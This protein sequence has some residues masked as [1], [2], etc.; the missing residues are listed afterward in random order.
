LAL[1]PSVSA[2]A[3]PWRWWW[4]ES[5]ASGEALARRGVHESTAGVDRRAFWR[6]GAVPLA[7]VRHLNPPVATVVH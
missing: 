6:V 1:H 3:T 5:K 4:N 7:E 2:A